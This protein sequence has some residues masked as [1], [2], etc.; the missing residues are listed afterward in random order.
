MKEFLR[1]SGNLQSVTLKTN[2]NGR[3]QI[4]SITPDC[5]NGWTGK[6]YSDCNVTVTAIPDAGASFA[7]WE[8]DYAG[9]EKT[10][11]MK[12]SKAM[13][14]QANFADRPAIG[15]VNA[16]GRVNIADA[17]LL[18]KY[19]LTM[20]DAKLTDWKA[21]DLDENGILNT[22]DLVLLKRELLSGS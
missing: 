13:R 2:G 9:N 22:T 10:V 8:G 21:A 6:Y 17:V 1:L 12:L 5:T 14:L 19:L 11:T 4:N 3:I 20:P 15:D 7:G 18:Q 16:D